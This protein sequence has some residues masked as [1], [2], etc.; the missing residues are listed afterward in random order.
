VREIR[1][2]GHDVASHGYG[3]ELVY[4]IG[5]ERFAEDLRKSAGVI[6]EA[7]GVRPHGYR[8]PSFSIDRRAGWAFD[9]LAEQS[10]TYD[11]SIFPVKHPRYGVPGF[12]RSPRR[13][14]A[15]GGAVLREFP[16]TTLRV[17]SL[18]VG[19]S[20]GAWLRVLPALVAQVAFARM[21]AA[22]QP[23]V[24]YVHP[25]E[26]DPE[27]PRVRVSALKRFAHYTNLAGTERRLATLLERFRFGTMEEAFRE[28]PG[29]S[30]E[31]VEVEA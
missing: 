8:A 21:N 18:N 9:V 31:P 2:R 20:G 14:R 22:G 5:R 24:L 16:M 6:E 17:A 25:W 1:E 23:A 26:L 4:R 12:P 29:L 10:F 27:Q 13:V 30:E 28:A 19:A 3:H 15:P 7:A 11:S